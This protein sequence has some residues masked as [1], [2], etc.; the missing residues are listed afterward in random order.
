MN[1][2]R[3]KW[4]YW[5]D[6]FR[7]AQ[8]DRALDEEVRSHVAIETERRIGL[9]ELAAPGPTACVAWNSQWVLR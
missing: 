1:W 6:V 8:L 9:G 3:L 5:M 7:R 4:K 2:Q